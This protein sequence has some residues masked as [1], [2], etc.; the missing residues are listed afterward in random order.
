MESF[1]VENV[2]TDL[3]QPGPF[4][5]GIRRAPSRGYRLN[6]HDTLLALRNA[7]ALCAA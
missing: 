1:A 7:L 3:P 4:E 6:R 5:P 2:L